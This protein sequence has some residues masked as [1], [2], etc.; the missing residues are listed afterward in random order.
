[1]SNKEWIFIGALGLLWGS[2]FLFAELLLTRLD[3]ILIVYLRVAIASFIMLPLLL[4]KHWPMKLSLGGLFSLLVMGLL[5]N[6]IPFSLIV[7]GQQ[8]TTAGLASILNA[9]T[10]FLAIIMAALFIPSERLTFNRIIGVLIGIF[11]VVVAVDIFIFMPSATQTTMQDNAGKY[12]IL[13]AT[14]S[15]A[16]AALWGKKY[17]GDLSPVLAATGML[18]ASTL[19]MTPYAL[20]HYMDEIFTIGWDM[21]G[22]AF[23]L[24]LLCSVFAY[25]LYFKILEISGPGN[26]L[27]CT[28]LI[29][30]SAILL[31]AIMLNQAI[32]LYE[33]IGMILIIIG[34]LILDGRILNWFKRL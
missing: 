32:T 11:G 25:L 16:F 31:E 4:I 19:I 9:N 21:L 1:M 5:N 13:L 3:P 27:I 14:L 28:I 24:A 10:S 17:L 34:L 30:P 23:L 15:Y 8:S 29:P 26:L 2:S 7:A 6:V 18:T 33:F 12:F 20:Y 22:I